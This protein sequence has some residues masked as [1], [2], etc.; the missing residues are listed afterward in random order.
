MP[1]DI[2][3][4]FQ[5]YPRSQQRDRSGVT[6]GVG[7]FFTRWRD[8]GHREAAP[9]RRVQA[10]PA[11]EPPIR[12]ATSDEQFTKPGFWS[13]VSQVIKDRLA[14]SA[15]QRQR[16]ART[17]LRVTY[18]QATVFPVYVL[19]TQCRDFAGAKSI[20][21]QQHEYRVVASTN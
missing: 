8:V 11:D 6:K 2:A 17:S 1:Q 4:Q 19:K 13:A 15:E 21:R 16:R 5:R 7:S 3:D 9:N 14:G 12:C 20:A 18:M 10:R